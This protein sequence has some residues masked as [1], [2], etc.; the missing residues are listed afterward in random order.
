MIDKNEEVSLL[1]VNHAPSFNVDSKVDFKVKGN[2][3]FD[4]LKI[5]QVTK[6]MKKTLIKLQK[7]TMKAMSLTGKR[8]RLNEGATRNKCL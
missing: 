5:L 3:V 8:T 6:K 7:K 1:E 2:L 4:T